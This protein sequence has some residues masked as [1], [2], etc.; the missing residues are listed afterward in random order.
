MSNQKL[1]IE[2][3]MG[4][5]GKSLS[6]GMYPMLVVLKMNEA[7][8]CVSRGQRGSTFSG[9]PSAS[10]VA[11]TAPDVTIEEKLVERCQMLS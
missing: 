10:D 5:F 6:G 9:N 2:P 11:V 7:M 1:G 4:I 8:F 3:E